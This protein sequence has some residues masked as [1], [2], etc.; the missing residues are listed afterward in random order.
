M[1]KDD[2]TYWSNEWGHREWTNK[3][4]AR[5]IR[6]YYWVDRV[7]FLKSFEDREYTG[8]MKFSEFAQFSGWEPISVK[9]LHK[10]S[11]PK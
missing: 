9:Q 2:K 4:G 10:E 3:D 1:E 6:S 7:I 8:E 11:E 5:A